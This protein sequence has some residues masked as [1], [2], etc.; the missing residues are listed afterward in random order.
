[1][2]N[3]VLLLSDEHNPRY[4]STYGHDVV[5]TPNMD[6]LAAR[7]TVYENAY[8][9][10]PLCVPSRTALM[11]GRYTHE[12][13]AYN[14][15]KVVERRHPGYGEVLARQGVHTLYVGGGSNLFRD[16][17]ALGFSEMRGVT[18]TGRRL[19]TRMIR[20]ERPSGKP[21]RTTAPH[22]PVPDRYAADTA[23]I[24]DAIEWIRTRAPVIDSPWTMTI[25]IDPPHPPYTTEPKYWEMYEGLEDLPAHG[26]EEL[27]AQHPYAQDIRENGRWDY[28]DELV[29][30]LRRGYFGAVSYV[31]DQLGRL[32]D[33]VDDAGMG[34]DTVVLYSADHGEMLGTFGLWGKTSLYEDS[35]RIPMLAAGPGFTPGRRVRTPVGSL[36]LQAAMFHAVGAR[37][38]EAWRGRPLQQIPVDDPD[39]PVLATYHGHNTRGGAFMLR[40][41]N[42]KLIHN[43]QAPDQLFDVHDDPD[44]L[45]DLWASHSAV[46]TRLEEELRAMCDPEAVERDAEAVRAQ[47]FAA[48]HALRE[49]HGSDAR[50]VPWQE[51]S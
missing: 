1:M 35:V 2:P 24:D 28:P 3:V 41:G 27:S 8:C 12:T 48:E 33:A 25:G 6:R 31:D 36:D 9:P 37:R 40:M 5:R 22:G 42:W 18:R 38:P 17:F 20:A 34:E 50:L 4:S 45:L 14:N 43:S 32:L 21:M 11:T 51:A 46:V 15:S 7:G 16:P 49:L 19:G 13:Q 26:T 44:E 39:R 23:H 47:Q 10:S 29:R 30:T